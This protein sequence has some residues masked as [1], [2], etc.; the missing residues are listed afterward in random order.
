MKTIVNYTDKV[1]VVSNRYFSKEIP[2]HRSV[3]ISDSEMNGDYMFKFHY[4]SLKKQSKPL[5]EETSKSYVGGRYYLNIAWYSET[6]LPMQTEVNTEAYDRIELTDKTPKFLFLSRPFRMTV[7]E[8]VGVKNHK[9][10]QHF[11][12][13]HASEQKRFLRYLFTEMAVIL[14]LVGACAVALANGSWQNKL[15]T[16]WPFAILL[17]GCFLRKLYYFIYHMKG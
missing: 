6:H 15:M 16:A 3:A 4:F 7:L 12:F 13:V 8:Q 2:I 17:A 1:V 11:S 14:L 5:V 10:K 9:A